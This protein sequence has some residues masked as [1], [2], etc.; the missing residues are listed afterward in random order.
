MVFERLDDEIL[1]VGVALEDLLLSHVLEDIVT[2]EELVADVANQLGEVSL[3]VIAIVLHPLNHGLED[4]FLGQYAEFVARDQ[5]YDRVEG[6][7][8]EFLRGT[9]LGEVLA[10]VPLGLTQQV[11]TRVQ[12]R[13]TDDAEHVGRVEL[14]TEEIAARI[15][16][17]GEL[18]QVGCRQKSLY[19][20][21]AH[22]NTANVDKSNE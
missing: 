6:E 18:E 17:L 10:G 8:H 5:I 15:A 4:V 19:V 13:E 21:L 3:P 9:H 22:F 1:A 2:G 7:G 14:L 20:V 16:D 11:S 12:V